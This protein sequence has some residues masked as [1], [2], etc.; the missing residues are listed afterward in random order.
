MLSDHLIN[1]GLVFVWRNNFISGSVLQQSVEKFPGDQ[2]RCADEN[3]VIK[4]SVCHFI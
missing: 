4:W 3:G 2:A 1:R